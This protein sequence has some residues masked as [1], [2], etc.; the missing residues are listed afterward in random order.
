MFPRK[1]IVLNTQAAQ[2]RAEGAAGLE[3]LKETLIVLNRAIDESIVLSKNK[4]IELEESVHKARRQGAPEDAFDFAYQEKCKLEN[5]MKE[6]VQEKTRVEAESQRLN[7]PMY[8]SEEN[9]AFSDHELCRSEFRCPITGFAMIDPVMNSAG[10]TYER[11]AIQTW[12]DKGSNTDP[13]TRKIIDKSLLLSN[14][15]LKSLIETARDDYK[16]QSIHTV[17][18]K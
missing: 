6:L 3:K 15:A 17:M 1:I 18:K 7:Q 14:L 16:T 4:M 10:I 13:S 11:A 9:V 8:A 5:E 2:L 12:Y